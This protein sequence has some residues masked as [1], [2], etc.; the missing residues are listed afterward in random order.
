MFG[1]VVHKIDW[2][3]GSGISEMD[4]A[5]L[6]AMLPSEDGGEAFFLWRWRLILGAAGY[7]A[8]K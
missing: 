6:W 1:S 4:S 8:E 5:A 2:Q 7:Y 3:L